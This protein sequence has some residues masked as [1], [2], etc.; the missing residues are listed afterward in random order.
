[1]L[2]SSYPLIAIAIAIVIEDAAHEMAIKLRITTAK[3]EIEAPEMRTRS[4]CP[5]VIA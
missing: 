3:G 2:R 4:V 5:P 1:M